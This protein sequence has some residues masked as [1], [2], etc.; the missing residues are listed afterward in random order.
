[1]AGQSLQISEKHPYGVQWLEAKNTHKST[2]A[3]L[4]QRSV[5]LA[6]SDLLDCLVVDILQATHARNRHL[7]VGDVTV[8]DAVAPAMK[9][10]LLATGP[11][12]LHDRGLSHVND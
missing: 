5:T 9:G 7:K 12:V 11:G 1:M 3:A 4:W 2:A 6:R 8:L 10:D